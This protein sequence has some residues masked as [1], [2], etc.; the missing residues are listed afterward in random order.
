MNRVVAVV[1]AAGALWVCGGCAM[2]EATTR[3]VAYQGGV[4][5]E[6]GV[7]LDEE[8]K[9]N[10]LSDDPGRNYRELMLMTG[11]CPGDDSRWRV[12]TQRV[13]SA[14]EKSAR[15]GASEFKLGAIDGWTDAAHERVWLVERSSGRVVAT[16]DRRSGVVT[17]IDDPRPAWAEGG[18]LMKVWWDAICDRPRERGT[19]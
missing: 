13:I 16:W 3:T 9:E 5:R 11:T 6:F 12:V 14:K 2:F 18:E 19:R 8:S 7:R 17:G 10:M 4:E 1:S 15:D